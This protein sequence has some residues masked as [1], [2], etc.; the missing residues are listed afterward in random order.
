MV[1]VKKIR[2]GLSK[3]QTATFLSGIPQP[4]PEQQPLPQKKRS[5]SRK[6]A[7]YNRHDWVSILE[8]ATTPGVEAALIPGQDG[9]TPR[10]TLSSMI[11]QV[12]TW[13]K[14]HGIVITTRTTLKPSP[15][16]L[17]KIVGKI[18]KNG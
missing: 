9:F 14:K 7:G 6:W 11:A 1:L 5:R 8:P 17:V 4:E 18:A 13:A 15:R 3:K 16:V 12:H 2:S 10:R